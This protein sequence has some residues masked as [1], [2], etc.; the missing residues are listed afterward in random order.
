MIINSLRTEQP[1]RTINKN[2]AW[3]LCDP[4]SSKSLKQHKFLASEI[5]MEQDFDNHFISQYGAK[6]AINL[7]HR[8][9]ES[10]CQILSQYLYLSLRYG[11]YKFLMTSLNL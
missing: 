11:Q 7:Y 6:N 10:L 5:R 1:E 3:R 2:K 8:N 4:R 9:Q